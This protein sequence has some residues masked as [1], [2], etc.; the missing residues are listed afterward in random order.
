MLSGNGIYPRNIQEHEKNSL[1]KGVKSLH[2]YIFAT[3]IEYI[4][5][6]TISVFNRY[7]NCITQVCFNSFPDIFWSA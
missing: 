4:G 2:I 6:R 3:H 7:L 5:M 1:A